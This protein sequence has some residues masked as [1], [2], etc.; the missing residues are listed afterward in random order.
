MGFLNYIKE[1][2][3]SDVISECMNNYRIDFLITN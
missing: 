2:K 1:Q 3:N